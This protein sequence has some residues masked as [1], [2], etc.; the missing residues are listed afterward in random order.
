[1]KPRILAQNPDDLLRGVH[2]FSAALFSR[3]G[4]AFHDR[5]LA[6]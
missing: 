4:I 3:G 2:H 6:Q 5:R 1:M